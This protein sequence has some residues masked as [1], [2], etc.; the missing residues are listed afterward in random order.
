MADLEVDTQGQGIALSKEAEYRN[1]SR[2]ADENN[3]I[4]ISLK[5]KVA[6]AVP[7]SAESGLN[8][9][10][11]GCGFLGIYHVGVAAALRKYASHLPIDYISG[12]SAGAMAATCLLCDCNLG[13]RRKNITRAGIEF[14]SIYGV[15]LT[16]RS[17]DLT[18]FN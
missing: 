12:T 13:M 8:F 6:S 15:T 5:T 9:S 7:R 14:N 16:S 2:L 3:N 1:S 18:V 17:C 11:A 10:F 4:S